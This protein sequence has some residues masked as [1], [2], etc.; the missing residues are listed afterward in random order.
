MPYSS[1]EA[2]LRRQEIVARIEGRGR[3]AEH[4]DSSGARQ[5]A[6]PG[7]FQALNEALFTDQT[8]GAAARSRHLLD[9]A[10]TGLLSLG[11]GHQEKLTG[12]IAGQFVRAAASNRRQIESTS[13]AQGEAAED[14]LRT[15]MEELASIDTEI[16]ASRRDLA[17]REA[18]FG[19]PYIPSGPHG[20]YIRALRNYQREIA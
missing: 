18:E 8:R 20:R 9:Q 10:Q 2:D 15:L 4:I 3:L 11:Q 5:R 14:Q 17:V 12:S 1:S 6:Q 16:L 13:I 7:Y 19:T